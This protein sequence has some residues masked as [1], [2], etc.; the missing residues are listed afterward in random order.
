MLLGISFSI[1][2]RKCHDL[3]SEYLG[4]ANFVRG[5]AESLF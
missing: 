1:G 3:L 2:I 5:N 4:L